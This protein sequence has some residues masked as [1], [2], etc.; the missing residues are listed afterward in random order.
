I[1]GDFTG[2]GP[3]YIQASTTEILRDDAIRFAAHAEAQGCK[4]IRDI[5][6]NVPHALPLMQRRVPEASE[7]LYRAA[8][9]LR[10]HV[11]GARGG[12]R[13]AVRKRSRF[14]RGGEAGPDGV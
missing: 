8:D 2:C 12:R 13:M 1:V 6:P 9:L 11:K 3:F 10:A 5:W 4:V 14:V 7:V